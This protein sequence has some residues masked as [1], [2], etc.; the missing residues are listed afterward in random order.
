[1]RPERSPHIR[2]NRWDMARAWGL[3]PGKAP[4]DFYVAD[5][6]A[7]NTRPAKPASLVCKIARCFAWAGMLML[8]LR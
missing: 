3:T 5:K 2:L 8:R 4:I 1:M 7:D 6:T